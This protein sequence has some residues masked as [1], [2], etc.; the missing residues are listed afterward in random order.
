MPLSYSNVLSSA[1]KALQNKVNSSISPTLFGSTPYK[2]TVPAAQ[3]SQIKASA[4]PASTRSVVPASTPAAPRAAT[5]PASSPAKASYK[6]VPITPGNEAAQIAKIDA[7]QNTSTTTA[8]NS[9]TSS[10]PI[11]PAPPTYS[12]LVGNLVTN[13]QTTAAGGQMTPEELKARQRL[14]GLPGVQGAVNANIESHPS[15]NAF[16][17]GRE[18]VA[19]RNIEAQRQ[20]LAGQVDAYASERSANT[21]AN[22]AAGTQYN[23]AA[24]LAQPQLGSYG[25]TYYNPLTG[26]N[27]GG[28]NLDPQTQA[29]SLAQKV[30]SGQMTYDQAI[31]SIGYAGSA[32]TN[33]LNQA[34]TS[35][36][37]NPLQL[38]AQGSATQGVI[39]T[40]TGTQAGYQS[41]L[42]QGQ[43]LQAQL[44]D[45]ITTFGL[46]PTDLNKAN[47][48]LQTIAKNIS[49]PHY[50]QLENYVNDI[51]NTYAQVLTPPGGSATD[52]SRGIASSMLDATASGTSLIDTMKSLDNAARAKIAGVSTTGAG[53]GASS[54]AGT[55]IQTKAGPVNTSW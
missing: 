41:A 52:T 14:A 51:A 42:Q 19:G 33:F 6:G 36:G 37:G 9:H 1:A 4:V 3:L 22:S 25:Q 2:S 13:A 10:A 54:S 38:Q 50:K 11:P 44:T 7:A 49:N 18:A 5:I 31:S 26:E 29:S 24:N 55:I 30:I 15:D 39:N 21:A 47:L 34:I 48:G 12:G 8:G 43:N 16:Q 32:G 28:G 53:N 23:A 45:L 27:S 17:M 35:A 40:Q 20:S 46:N